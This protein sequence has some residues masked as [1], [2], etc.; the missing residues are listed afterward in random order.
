MFNLGFG[1]M[2]LLAAIAL[3][4]LG[5]KELPQLARIL[6]K[7]LRELRNAMNDVSSSMTKNIVQEVT[8][9]EAL[10]KAQDQSEKSDES[11]PFPGSEDPKEEK[12]HS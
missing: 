9:T 1:E 2:L 8:K 3:V 10:E 11:R 12:K 6:G 7:T 4:F 5:P